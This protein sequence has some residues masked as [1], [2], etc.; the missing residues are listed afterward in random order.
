V[1]KVTVAVLLGPGQ[2]PPDG[3]ELIA[4]MAAVRMADNAEALAGALE[5]AQILFG[6]DFR[7]GLLAGAWPHAGSLRWIHAASVGVDA[8]L[9][10]PV[11]ASDVVVTN[12]R[13]VFERPIAEYV[14]GLILVFAKD[15]LTTLALQRERRWL[16]RDA[17]MIQGRRVLILGAGG[18]ARELAPLLR[19]AGMEVQVVGRT[20]RDADSVLGRVV[21][22]SD[23]DSLL[24]EADFVVLALP[25]TAETRGFLDARRIGLL[26]REARLINVGR[27][28][29]ID[30]TALVAALSDGQIAGAALDVFAEEPLPARHPLWVMDRVIVSP[31]M[32]G[33]PF[34][35]ERAVV[36]GFCENLRRW[37]AGEALLNVVDKRLVASFTPTQGHTASQP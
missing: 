18:V 1:E 35:W 11:V 28:D 2:A 24:P 5:G 17:E 25:L 23:V 30:E 8:L 15:L 36:E 26:H 7:T 31:H 21:A 9:V 10:D 12:T 34:G 4:E 20:A 27:G 6:W 13:G 16:H 33:D 37:L 14:L 19:A 32:S 29:L 22:S 3:S